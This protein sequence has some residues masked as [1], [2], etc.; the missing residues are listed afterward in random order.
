M[1]LLRILYYFLFFL[2]L[3]FLAWALGKELFY[4][5]LSASLFESRK[6]HW[7]LLWKECFEEG[8]RNTVE[9][10]QRDL[11]GDRSVYFCCVMTTGL[12]RVNMESWGGRKF[13]K[14]WILWVLK[15]AG[16]LLMWKDSWCFSPRTFCLCCV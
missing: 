2:F 15:N 9:R 5:I 10:R 16:H 4:A 8:K 3:F 14:D 1:L 13:R 7:R 6:T 11:K 12:H